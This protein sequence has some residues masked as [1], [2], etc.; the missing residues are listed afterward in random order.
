[1]YKYICFFKQER[2]EMDDFERKEK[3]GCKEF[4]FF[5][6]NIKK[7]VQGLTDSLEKNS[8]N[9]LAYFLNF[10]PIISIF[11]FCKETCIS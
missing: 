6:T 7:N 10:K 3:M 11:L 2:S 9:I 5:L 1:M 8:Q 4:L